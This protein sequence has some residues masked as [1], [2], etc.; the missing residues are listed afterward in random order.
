MLFVPSPTCQQVTEALHVLIA[1][2][3]H[4]APACQHVV[5]YGCVG[6]DAHECD[7]A[8]G[9][10]IAA[11]A[12]VRLQP[13]VHF[14]QLEPLLQQNGLVGQHL[15]CILSRQLHCMQALGWYGHRPA[16]AIE[17]AHPA[18]APLRNRGGMWAI[19][20]CCLCWQ[21]GTQHEAAARSSNVGATAARMP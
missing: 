14:A 19:C 5:P 10:A 7:G 17:L 6:L 18:V 12:A 20:L 21:G 15:R 13:G 1:E 2:P 4:G 3:L 11:A 9:V 16:G 8:S